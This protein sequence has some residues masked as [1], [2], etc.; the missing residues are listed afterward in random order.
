MQWNPLQHG[1]LIIAFPALH[2]GIRRFWRKAAFLTCAMLV[3]FL[4][5]A[6]R[7]VSLTLLALYVDPSLLFG[8][9]HHQGGIIFFLL[10]LFLLLPIYLALQV[11]QRSG[12]KHPGTASDSVAGS[13]S[14][15]AQISRG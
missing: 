5:N 9:L 4:K 13:T 11:S 6:I 7:I 1:L 3:M 8:K 2:F 15:S 14:P 12:Q 10:G